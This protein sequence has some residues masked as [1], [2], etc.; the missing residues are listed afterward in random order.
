MTAAP[1]R[2]EERQARHVAV[3][4]LDR[5]LAVSPPCSA[6]EAM[7][8]MRSVVALRDTL[9]ERRR[10]EGASPGLDRRLACA[11]AALSLT[12]SGAVP[13]SGFRRKRLEKARGALAEGAED[14]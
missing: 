6:Q 12:W 14:T 3:A 11:N 10:E 13:V 8:A 5:L 1:P 2:Q 4:G 7:E 9:L